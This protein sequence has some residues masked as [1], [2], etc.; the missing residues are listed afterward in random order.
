MKTGVNIEEGSAAIQLS[1]LLTEEEKFEKWGF[2]TG[3]GRWGTFCRPAWH[4][5]DVS[6]SDDTGT[7]LDS[8]EDLINSAIYI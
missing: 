3:T 5:R 1:G 6:I 7:P 4:G 8:G 2:L